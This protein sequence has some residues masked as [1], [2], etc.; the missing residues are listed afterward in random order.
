MNY[1]ALELKLRH[2]IEKRLSEGWLVSTVK[3]SGRISFAHNGK[4]CALGAAALDG[5]G[6][7]DWD[8]AIEVL[9]LNSDFNSAKSIEQ[10][11][12]GKER[13]FAVRRLY[14]IGARIRR[15]YVDDNGQVE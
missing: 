6:L 10:G 7:P 8:K 15:I 13:E 3:K 5:E 1:E 4:C 9:G 12:E 11:F 14:D 2:V